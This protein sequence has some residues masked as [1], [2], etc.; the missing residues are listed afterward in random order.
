M[1]KSYDTQIGDLKRFFPCLEISEYYNFY[2]KSLI[3]KSIVVQVVKKQHIL[4]FK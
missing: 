2:Q 4:E 1:C 3:S